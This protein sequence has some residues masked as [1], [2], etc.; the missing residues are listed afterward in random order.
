MRDPFRGKPAQQPVTQSLRQ[1]NGHAPPRTANLHRPAP[2]ATPATLSQRQNAGLANRDRNN[3]FSNIN[4][5]R[6]TR[7]E[8]SRGQRSLGNRPRASGRRR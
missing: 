6:Q 5:G 2:R 8:S 3:A 1:R 4:S 7:M